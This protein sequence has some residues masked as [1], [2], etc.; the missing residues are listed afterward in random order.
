MMKLL[1]FFNMFVIS[2][3]QGFKD[4]CKIIDEFRFE[5]N[6]SNQCQPSDGRQSRFINL[7][8]YGNSVQ[9]IF[10]NLRNNLCFNFLEFESP[11]SDGA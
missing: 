1:L 8:Q 11:F 6:Y 5:T 10:L 7:K 9:V 3:S 2:L 4:E